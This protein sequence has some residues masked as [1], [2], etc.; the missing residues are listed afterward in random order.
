MIKNESKQKQSAHFV[1]KKT[2][3]KLFQLKKLFPRLSQD[4][5]SRL[6]HE[7]EDCVAG[8]AGTEPPRHAPVEGEGGGWAS[9]EVSEDDGH[10]DAQRIPKE[11]TEGAAGRCS[12]L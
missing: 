12:G 1:A 6:C 4:F 10:R 9:D 3:P 7:R 2:S 5:L 11:R 8:L